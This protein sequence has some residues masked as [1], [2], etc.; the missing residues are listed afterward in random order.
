MRKG[1]NVLVNP[2][3]LLF[4]FLRRWQC[5]LITGSPLVSISTLSP[6]PHTDSAS[7]L[8]PGGRG[9]GAPGLWVRFEGDPGSRPFQGAVRK[10]HSP[11]GSSGVCSEACYRSRDWG[12]S[13]ELWGPYEST[14][15]TSFLEDLPCFSPIPPSGERAPGCPPWSP[16]TE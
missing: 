9:A 4:S 10:R 2:R 6:R 7:P 16:A 13:T 5:G 3:A 11:R 14:V 1:W 12:Q 15:T 8:D